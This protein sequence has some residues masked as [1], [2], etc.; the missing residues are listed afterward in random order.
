MGDK[1]ERLC[2]AKP[3]PPASACPG[4]PNDPHPCGGRSILDRRFNQSGE[5]FQRS[6][7]VQSPGKG[8]NGVD[9]PPSARGAGLTGF[10]GGAELREQGSER[11]NR[12]PLLGAAAAETVR[13]FAAAS[14]QGS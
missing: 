14:C 5:G 9:T 4:L 11:R 8:R 2:T 6:P 13:R 7:Q 1:L 12:K 3:P 10:T